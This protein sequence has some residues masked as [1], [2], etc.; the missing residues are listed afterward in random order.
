M[1]YYENVVFP[2]NCRGV[3]DVTKAPYFVDNTGK[4]DCT[5]TLIQILNDILMENVIEVK[6]SY[7]RLVNAPDGTREGENTKRNGLVSV[8]SP[9]HIS[10]PPTLY[11]PNGTYLVSDTV[12]YTLTELH[13]MMYHQTVGG[14]ELNCCIRFMG[15]NRE[16][17]VI[18]LQ[19]NCKGFEF[20]QER[21][22]VNFMQGER[23]NVSYSNYFENI[24]IDVGAGNPGAVGMVFF[25]NNNG[26]VRNVTI[27]SSDPEHRGSA[28]IRI[29]HEIHSACNFYNVEVDGFDYGARIT[30][31]R[32]FCHFENIVLRNQ[33]RYGFH[34]MNTSVQIA[35]LY[36]KNDIP[37]LCVSDGAT[38]HVVMV[39]AVLE[40]DGTAYEAIKLDVGA[41]LFLRNVDTQGYA[42]AINRHWREELIP[43]GYIEEYCYPEGKALFGGEAKSLNLPVEQMP[44]LPR[45]PLSR[46]HCV[47]EFG[48]V[49]DGE[50][51]DTE[52]LE[53]AF[54]SGNSVIWF[55]PGRYVISRSVEIPAT[56]EHVHFMFCDFVVKEPLK[57]SSDDA[58]FRLTGETDAPIL[59]EKMQSWYDCTGEMRMF[60][61]DNTRTLVMRDLHSEEAATY[62]NTVPGGKVFMENVACTIGRKKIYGHI[63]G[64]TFLRKE[65]WLHGINPERSQVA[66]KNIGGKLWWCGFKTE[67]NYTVIATTEG[68]QSDVLGGVASIGGGKEI[69]LIL[70]DNS[71]VSAIL[72][73]LGLHYHWTFPLAVREIRGEEVRDIRAEELPSRNPPW[74]FL[75]LYSGK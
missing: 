58:V 21:P 10:Q 22:V 64:M 3:L 20:G 65:V 35:G 72:A 12:T 61:Q 46:W 49:G 63:T 18:K 44:D 69:P 71:S 34:V 70:N 31:Y 52:A 67:G 75:P 74:Y 54:Q 14:H 38:A 50:T 36:S 28:G 5:E 66:V 40:S 32:T 45:A 8:L 30:T 24:T 6:K 15:Q 59:L 13:N 19:D 68:G 37:A 55:Q 56:V 48:A 2:E 41:C 51:D 17:T 1:R 62:F 43:T 42:H 47:T 29:R 11:F 7:E 57:T 23:S 53:S 25:A 9:R 39:D 33:R 16:K 4:T 60:R 73:T 26:A 27:R